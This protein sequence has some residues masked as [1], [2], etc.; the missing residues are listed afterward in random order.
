MVPA[1]TVA[2]NA[3]K[4]NAMKSVRPTMTLRVIDCGQCNPDHA[5]I[6]RLLEA[7][8]DV[9]V[10]RTADGDETMSELH[11]SPADLVLVNRKLDADYTDGIDVLKRIKA[12][13]KTRHIPVMLI[14]NYPEYQEQAMAAGAIRGFGKDQLRSSETVTLLKNV[15]S[16]REHASK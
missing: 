7:N 6:R 11:A 16:A 13:A 10:I 12:D 9:L 14:T 4:S 8:F 3:M 1:T 15:L 5:A 2:P